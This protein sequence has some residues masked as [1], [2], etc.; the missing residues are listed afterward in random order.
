LSYASQAGK[1]APDSFEVSFT[2]TSLPIDFNIVAAEPWIVLKDVP[3]SG[4]TT[5]ASVWVKADATAL[6]IGDY[7]GSII[8][9]PNDTSITA[10]PHAV[11]VTFHVTPPIVYPPGDFNCDGICDLGDLSAIISYMTGGGNILKHCN[12][13]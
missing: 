11:T 5:P 1:V 3:F 2:S 12:Q 8:M 10:T 7:T 4:F 9:T 13:F 6:P